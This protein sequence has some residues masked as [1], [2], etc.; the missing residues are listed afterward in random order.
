MKFCSVLRKSHH[1]SVPNQ[2]SPEGEQG[3]SPP[4]EARSRRELGA[5]G[6]RG[7]IRSPPVPHTWQDLLA[8][9]AATS[10]LPGGNRELV[11]SQEHRWR[12]QTILE[13]CKYLLSIPGNQASSLS[14]LLQNEGVNGLQLFPLIIFI[15]I[16]GSWM[17]CFLHWSQFELQKTWSSPKG[18]WNG[19]APCSQLWPQHSNLLSFLSSQL[20]VSYLP[21]THTGIRKLLH[22]R[23]WFFSAVLTQIRNEWNYSAELKSQEKRA[24]NQNGTQNPPA[25]QHPPFIW[26]KDRMLLIP[27][28]NCT[29]RSHTHISKNTEGNIKQNW[30]RKSARFCFKLTVEITRSIQI[31]S[32]PC[33]K[34]KLNDATLLQGQIWKIYK[35]FVIIRPCKDL[36]QWGL[37][38]WQKII[39]HL[40]LWHLSLSEEVQILVTSTLSSALSLLWRQ[41]WDAERKKGKG[42]EEIKLEEETRKLFFSLSSTSAKKAKQKMHRKNQY[43]AVKTKP[44]WKR[45]QGEAGTPWHLF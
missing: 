27:D 19:V 14:V 40:F 28:R 12:A 16:L 7:R 32:S 11:W 42:D 8:H 38:C 24:T 39:L 36:S 21:Q 30:R 2:N 5:L 3:V 45:T 22:L 25:A 26:C 10:R 43:K 1:K 37:W 29:S 20:W 33:P 31:S 23:E 9:S 35:S 18:P 13:C 4:L 34:D 17:C 6:G 44:R 41:S 15:W